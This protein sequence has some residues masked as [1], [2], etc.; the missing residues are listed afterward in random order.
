MV[1]GSFLYFVIAVRVLTSIMFWGKENKLNKT[2]YLV[3][4]ELTIK[5]RK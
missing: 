1:F 5:E 2:S 3:P 4:R